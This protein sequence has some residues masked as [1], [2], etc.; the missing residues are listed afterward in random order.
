MC[1]TEHVDSIGGGVG[2][3]IREGDAHPLPRGLL[4]VRILKD[5]GAKTLGSAH[6]NEVSRW[7]QT[8]AL[9]AKEL[10]RQASEQAQIHPER[11]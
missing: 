9:E 6:S 5:L 7:L 2:C 11:E 3:Q 10:L 8:L 1:P 4:D